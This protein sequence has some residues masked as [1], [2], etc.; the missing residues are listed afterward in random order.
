MSHA[1]TTVRKG[2]ERSV[3]AAEPR[4]EAPEAGGARR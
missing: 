3:P 1:A 4:R 2:R